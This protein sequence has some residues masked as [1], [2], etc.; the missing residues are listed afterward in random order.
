MTRG[1]VPANARTARHCMSGGRCS[2]EKIG[3]S[4]RIIGV[5]SVELGSHRLA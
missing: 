1:K 2:T 4:R 5:A 3:T